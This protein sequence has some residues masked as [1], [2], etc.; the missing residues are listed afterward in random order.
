MARRLPWKE[1]AQVAGENGR[2]RAEVRGLVELQ[3][4]A[5]KK[6]AVVGM[7]FLGGILGL[8]LG[9]GGGWPEGQTRLP[10][11]VGAS[12]SS[13]AGPSVPLVPWVLVPVFYRSIS[14]PPNLTLPLIIH[15]CM[16]SSIGGIAGM[17]LGIGLKGW[18]GAVKGFVAGALGAA[19]GSL[20]FNIVHTVA[21]PLEW[22]FSPMPGQTTSR[23][24]AHL[25]V[26]LMTVVSVV[27]VLAGERRAARPSRR[28]AALRRG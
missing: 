5:E 3:N 23:M 4:E 10:R 19:L 21:F 16:Y 26:A 13:S 7:G 20:V 2:D 1:Q 15:T 8:T 14:Q 27:S 17:A 18:A 24:I 25:C 6:S 11:S 22:D 28:L 9:V 12:A